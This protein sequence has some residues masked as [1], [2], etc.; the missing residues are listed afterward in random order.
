MLLVMKKSI[1]SFD[2]YFSLEYTLLTTLWASILSFVEAVSVNMISCF[3][4]HFGVVADLFFPLSSFP[5]Y[6]LHIFVVYLAKLWVTPMFH[7]VV[8]VIY[9]LSSEEGFVFQ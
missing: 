7:L 6:P 2:F 8:F 4:R 3:L 5:L 9:S 1:R